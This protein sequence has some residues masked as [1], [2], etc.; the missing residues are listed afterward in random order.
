MHYLVEN[1]RDNDTSWKFYTK[2][3]S[4]C[5]RDIDA[6]RL[7]DSMVEYLLNCSLMNDNVLKYRFRNNHSSYS[8]NSG[9]S[10]RTQRG[11]PMGMRV[12]NA[13]ERC[14]L[15]GYRSAIGGG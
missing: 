12:E 6:F 7:L 13:E 4:F 10:L 9:A 8:R 15:Q 11:S 5:T 2:T 3:E 1:N 14:R